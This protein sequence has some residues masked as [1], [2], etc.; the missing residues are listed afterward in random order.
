MEVKKLSWLLRA[1]LALIGLAC[2]WRLRLELYDL[3]TGWLMLSDPYEASLYT[4]AFV[5]SLFL[6]LSILA[7]F[8][9]LVAAWG[10]FRQ[11]GLGR[12]FYQEK[13]LRVLGRLLGL[14][15]VL[16]A[17]SDGMMLSFRVDRLGSGFL[18]GIPA[19]LDGT[20]LLYIGL[21]LGCAA[22]TAAVLA[23]S[24][25][26]VRAAQLLDENALTV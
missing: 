6:T 3:R 11:A 19:M 23:L 15:T 22:L 7:V 18:W 5:C 10:I 16:L 8:P 12:G 20:M 24:R 26:A 1:L 9:C 2:L 21:T 4:R 13:R 17:A 25:S 14:E